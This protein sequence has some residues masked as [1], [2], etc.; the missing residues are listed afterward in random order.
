MMY[1]PTGKIVLNLELYLVNYGTVYY[2]LV[3]DPADNISKRAM[4]RK[5]L[6]KVLSLSQIAFLL[7]VPVLFWCLRQVGVGWV[8][9]EGVGIYWPT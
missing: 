5:F 2:F 9:V 4:E 8:H 3:C 1:F 6:F 7:D